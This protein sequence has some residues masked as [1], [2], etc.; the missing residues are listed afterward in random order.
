MAKGLLSRWPTGRISRTSPC[1]ATIDLLA[2]SVVSEWK[3]PNLN[4]DVA[5]QKLAETVHELLKNNS[6]DAADQLE[7]CLPMTHAAIRAGSKELPNAKGAPRLRLILSL[8]DD[9]PMPVVG[10]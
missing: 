6:E 5:K 9:T 4:P 2:K 8:F 3:L 10:N 1:K 7:R